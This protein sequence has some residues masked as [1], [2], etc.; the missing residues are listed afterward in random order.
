MKLSPATTPE[1][2]DPGKKAKIATDERLNRA[3]KLLANQQRNQTQKDNQK[4]NEEQL[5]TSKKKP[6][7]EKPISKPYIDMMPWRKSQDQKKP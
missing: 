1:N 4:K 3:A 5:N 7:A 2:E 6:V